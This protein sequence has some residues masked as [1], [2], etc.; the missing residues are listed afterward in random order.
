MSAKSVENIEF[1]DFQT[2]KALCRE[3][4]DLLRGMDISPNAIIEPTCGEGSFVRACVSAFPE[5]DVVLGFE[6]NPAYA[7][8]AASIKKA[9][10]RRKNVFEIDWPEAI[11]GLRD[12]ILM[13]GNPPW[14]TNSAMSAIGGGNVPRK[15]NA[16]GFRGLDAVTG[17]S[18]FDISEW[19]ISR[20]LES[21]SGRSAALA[22]L[23]KTTAARKALKKAWRK[24]LE[25][26]AASMHGIDAAR[27][28]GASV[29]ACLLLCILKPGSASRECRVHRSLRRDSSR[30]SFGIRDGRLMSDLAAAERC[31]RLL[32]RSPAGWRSGIK[33]DCSKVME[34]FP[35]GDG[36]FVNGFGDKAT[37]ESRFL[38]PMLKSSDLM[39]DAARPGRYMLVTQRSIGEST[40]NIKSEAPSTWKYL[41]SHGERLDARSSAVYRN[42]PRFSMF[43]VGP[44]AFS[45][46]KVAVSGFYKKPIFRPVGPHEGKPVVLD[47]TCY[48]L[49]CGSE[50]SARELA[51]LLASDEA[52]SFFD[53]LIFRDSK[54]PVTAD[55]LNSLDLGALA[56]HTGMDLPAEHAGSRA[57]TLDLA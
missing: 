51:A 35:E 3:V 38:Y 42:R 20:F 28:F 13:I 14:V 36:V 5:C 52:G 54:R 19:M 8:R 56:V 33:H 21:L 47:D 49:P 31:R 43:G 32:G 37:L 7:D 48:F 26:A 18:N 4:C 46:W 1:G 24:E 40:S 25:I 10:I 2:P 15:S 12:P 22:M 45:P 55:I 50:E 34:L 27:H 11:K 30:I 53:A 29:D 44:Y 6:I 9:S 41:S 57:G 39:K 23:C 17:K 16:E